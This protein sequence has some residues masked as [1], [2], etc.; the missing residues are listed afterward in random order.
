MY[1]AAAT[2]LRHGVLGLFHA[3]PRLRTFGIHAVSSVDDAT[4]K[5]FASLWHVKAWLEPVFAGVR[6]IRLDPLTAEACP[7]GKLLANFRPHQTWSPLAFAG[8]HAL[9]LRIVP[10]LPLPLGAGN[11]GLRHR[12]G[13]PLA[14]GA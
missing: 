8:L 10:L 13:G 1:R 2:D 4:W 9:G 14:F 3:D 11:V 6:C 12:V 5:S 7:F